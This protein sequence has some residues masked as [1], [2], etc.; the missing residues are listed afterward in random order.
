MAVELERKSE[1]P[2]ESGDDLIAI[3]NAYLEYVA[4][5]KTA[6]ETQMAG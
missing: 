6:A 3:A 1:A 4:R 5:L 2:A